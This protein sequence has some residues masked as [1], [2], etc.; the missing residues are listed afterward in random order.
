MGT[1]TRRRGG[2]SGAATTLVVPAASSTASRRACTSSAAES[3]RCSGSFARPRASAASTSGRQLGVEPRRR[4]DRSARVCQCLGGR[5]LALEGARA[6]EELEGDDGQRVAVARG[7]RALAAGLLGREVAG[8]ADDGA[9]LRQRGQVRGARDAEVGHVDLA[10][11]VEQQVGGLDVA[12]HDPARVCRVE[13]GR[14]LAAATRASGRSAV[15]PPRRSCPQASRRRGTP[16]RCTGDPRARRRRRLS[17]CR[18]R[19]TVGLRSAPRG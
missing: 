9:R 14:R 6:G 1:G 5:R 3:Y 17:P 2:V 16:S 13:R 11:V 18:E 7:R 12:V 15:L 10:V 8:R 19:S 4:R